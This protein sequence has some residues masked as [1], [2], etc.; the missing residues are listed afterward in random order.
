MSQ[1]EIYILVLCLIVFTLLVTLSATLIAVIVRYKRRLIACGQ[2]DEEI[3]KEYF[4][5]KKRSG[6]ASTY[7]GYALNIVLCFLFV[8][9]FVF[10]LC[11]NLH[12][13][14]FS[15]DVPTLRVVQSDSMARKHT[16]NKYLT[17]NSLNDQFQTHDII[18]TYQVPDEFELKLYDIVVYEV[19]EILVV[20]RIVGIEEPNEKHPACRHFRLQG[21]AVG[22]PDRYPV[23]YEQMRGIYRG[24]RIQ[25][26]GS[27]VTFL[28]TPAGWLCILLVVGVTLLSP[29]LDEIIE[30]ESKKRLIALKIIRVQDDGKK[31]GKKT[32]AKRAVRKSV[33]ANGSKKKLTGKVV[34][35]K[36]AKKPAT[37]TVKKPNRGKKQ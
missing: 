36:T 28:Q 23:K 4:E 9:F 13:D 8:Y 33:R 37:V 10:S 15:A 34:S 30:K 29:L 2:E 1:F 19:D 22:S 5:R 16:S 24:E 20:H 11:V 32:V 14:S 17:E 25:F 35:N 3:K 18:L 12:Q 7:F 31:R 21:D 6:S 27:F 26:L